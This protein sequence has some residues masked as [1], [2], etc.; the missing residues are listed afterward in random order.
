MT[1]S[2]ER[3]WSRLVWTDRVRPG[4]PSLTDS[5]GPP[6]WSET[7]A[8]CRPCWPAASSVRRRSAWRGLAPRWRTPP[9][10]AR[11]TA[12]A[13]AARPPLCSA[14]PSSARR[15]RSPA[16]RTP[17]APA[18]WPSAERAAA[19][20]RSTTC[21]HAPPPP[22]RRAQKKRRGFMSDASVWLKLQRAHVE[23][24][25]S[26]SDSFGSI[27]AKADQKRVWGVATIWDS[28]VCC[29]IYTVVKTFIYFVR[30]RC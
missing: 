2:S 14:P 10:S 12:P 3:Y 24:N 29:L 18:A 20:G 30:I 6:S 1:S 27:C 23:M 15:S 17:S 22:E 7:S 9:G 13:S 19:P 16:S 11:T 26:R 5:P 4:F 21:P 28:H 8:R 25:S